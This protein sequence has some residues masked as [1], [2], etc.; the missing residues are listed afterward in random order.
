MS[1]LYTTI[2]RKAIMENKISNSHYQTTADE[3]KWKKHF[4]EN[5][6]HIQLY[7]YIFIQCH[8]PTT[9][10]LRTFVE[11]MIVFDILTLGHSRRA[12]EKI[13]TVLQRR[14][15]SADTWRPRA[16][17]TWWGT[18]EKRSPDSSQCSARQYPETTQ[19][20][21]SCCACLRF[22]IC[23]SQ[24]AFTCSWPWLQVEFDTCGDYQ[25][26]PWPAYL[27]GGGFWNFWA[28]RKIVKRTFPLCLKSGH[29]HIPPLRLLWFMST[30][31]R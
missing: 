3:T 17:H 1:R 15:L 5:E 8:T 18:L 19:C 30:L 7:I 20:A 26:G 4:G 13:N 31:P 23:V 29:H 12:T 11:L 24:C 22:C 27:C 2:F 21:F 28:P 9:E 25:K 10:T 16:D 14:V 6:F